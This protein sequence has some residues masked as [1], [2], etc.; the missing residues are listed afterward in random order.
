VV[1]VP[2]HPLLPAELQR[3]YRE[4][5]L[6]EDTS[7]MEIL[8]ARARSRPD[9]PLYLGEEP[10]TYGEVAAAAAGFAAALA[11][12][13]IG[14]GDTV[15]APL[16]SGWQATVVSAAASALGAVL[17][18]LPSRCSP[19]QACLLAQVTEA[20]VLVISGRVLARPG[21]EE[22]LADLGERAPSIRRVYV[23][24]PDAAP[25]WAETQGH[26]SLPDAC[27]GGSLATLRSPP[28]DP[29]EI[30]LLLSTG[31]TT[32]PSKVVTHCEQAIVYAAG[33]YA[34]LCGLGS[35]DVVL[36]AG[37][38][39]HASG[40]VF[41]LYAPIIAGAAVLPL[42]SWDPARCVADVSRYAV[43]WGLLTGTHIYDLLGLPETEVKGLRSLRGISA[44]SGSDALYLEAERRFGFAIRRMYGLSECLGH[45]LM[46]LTAPPDRRMARDGLPF[47]GIEAMV[48]DQG[49]GESLGPGEVGEYVV[50]GPSLFMGYLGRAELTAESIHAGGYL[51]TGDLMS[52]DDLGY[53]KYV[54]R[55]KD[56]IR[57]AGVNI[58]PMEVERVLI[59]H[60]GIADVSVV[61]LPDPR[62][63]ERAVA[64]I[65]TADG[66]GPT[67]DAIVGFLAEREVPIQSHPERLV[68]VEEIP[69]TEFGK[70]NKAKLR[71]Q[72]LAETG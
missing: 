56:V 4:R 6:W 32:G 63:G 9:A 14:R 69:R 36:S 71:E 19:A 41:T 8:A 62:L 50:R 45:A 51:R 26:L 47:E 48:L 16:V 15:V 55:L 44:G 53:V 12:D 20:P 13:G 64:A 46:P 65:E 27:T 60:S 31:G 33:Q 43:S 57:R 3:S 30:A 61:G 68:V 28:R 54:G 37:P 42:V 40:T 17:A 10:K 49:S 23:A 38:Y 59:Q 52:I 7:L 21:W 22:A 25:A 29:T 72:L 24:D 5:G 66:P 18:P 11:A 34:Q 2:D 1:T 67:L 35:G 39:G 70:H 58:D